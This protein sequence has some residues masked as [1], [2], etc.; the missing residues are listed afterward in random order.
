MEL[1]RQGICVT[2]E[3]S[4]GSRLESKQHVQ[5]RE[6]PRLQAEGP[7]QP[8]R[9]GPAQPAWDQ[10]EF[11]FA[12]DFLDFVEYAVD[13]EPSIDFGVQRIWEAFQ[14]SIVRPRDLR[15]LLNRLVSDYQ[16][17]LDPNDPEDAG[18]YNYLEELLAEIARLWNGK[19]L[20]GHL[21][22]FHE[23]SMEGQGTIV[24]TEE[25]QKLAKRGRLAPRVQ[26]PLGNG[27][28]IFLHLFSGYRRPGDV[29]EAIHEYAT[30]MGWSAKALSVDIAT[31]V[32][33]GD[34]LQPAVQAKFVS[35]IQQGLVSGIAAGPPCETWSTARESAL[36]EYAVGPRP[37]RALD[38]PMGLETLTIREL[39]QILVGNRLLGVALLLVVHC[40]MVGVF[41]LLEH[42][43]K[44]TT[45]S[46]SIWKL[47]ILQ[48]LIGH[49]DVKLITVRQGLFGAK[50][51]KPTDLML[52]KPPRAYME[53]LRSHQVRT[54]VPKYHSIGLQ[55]NGNFETTEL[56][57]YPPA[58]CSAIAELWGQH[59]FERQ[60]RPCDQVGALPDEFV[61]IVQALFSQI[62]DSS[63]GPDFCPKGRYTA[64]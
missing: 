50:S 63:L 43:M 60:G 25:I 18:I 53:I 39:K 56:K 29:Q 45:P 20:M 40:L 38:T 19:W 16:R 49:P 7:L 32:E 62:G 52:V 28:L 10:A 59:I 12:E 24:A 34:L 42:P 5:R 41:A 8:P 35:A 54:T 30:Q 6:I 3:P 9:Q 22:G 31:S 44:P 2:P 47:P 58:L 46:P 33:Y 14:R 64:V 48:L 26:R 36:N 27:C 57:T 55:A 13:F 21:H 23:Q 37:V 4:T 17:D 1:A 11:E 51:S 61:E 15:L